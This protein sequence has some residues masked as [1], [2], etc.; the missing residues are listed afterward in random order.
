MDQKDFMP[1]QPTQTPA[2]Q[3]LFRI[4]NHT[5]RV[6]VI[7]LGY[8]GLPLM[9]AFHKA[10]LHVIGFD[11]DPQKIELLQRGEN[12]L[13]HLGHDLVKNM[14]GDRFNATADFSRLGEADA[15]IVYDIGEISGVFTLTDLYVACTRARVYLHLI[16]HEARSASLIEQA[17]ENG[18]LQASGA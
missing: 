12:Y 10:G 13:K 7:G 4:D 17:I 15:V 2:E 3:L 14:L 18:W 5:A 1:Q 11:I 8:V 16:V 6:G 9:A